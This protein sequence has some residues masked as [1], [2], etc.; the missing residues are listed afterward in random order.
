MLTNTGEIVK[1]GYI[2]LLLEETE[3]VG[4]NLT[5]DKLVNIHI[6]GDERK[7]IVNIPNRRV[8]LKVGHTQKIQIHSETIRLISS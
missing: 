7:P 5:S 2:N 8:K 6:G 1:W 3:N 4:K